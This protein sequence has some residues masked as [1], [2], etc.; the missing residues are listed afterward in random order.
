MQGTKDE[1]YAGTLA[2]AER[3]QRSGARHELVVLDGAPHG[4]ENW[5]GHAEWGF[6]KQRMVDWLK[7]TLQ[8]RK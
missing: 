6:Y 3:L 8:S 7:A 2:Y 1:L 4:M 5:E